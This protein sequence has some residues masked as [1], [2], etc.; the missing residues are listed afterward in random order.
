M[1]GRGITSSLVSLGTGLKPKSCAA[2][3]PVGETGV[4][5]GA[6]ADPSGGG[7][8]AR[9][10]RSEASGCTKRVTGREEEFQRL[11]NAEA[12]GIPL[13]LA[14]A[15]GRRFHHGG[16]EGRSPFAFLRKG[17]GTLLGCANHLPGKEKRQP[18]RSGQHRAD[19]ERGRDAGPTGSRETLPKAPERGSTR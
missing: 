2:T 17:R 6:R 3:L 9:K 12:P 11:G 1:G 4:L 18:P 13:G 14:P 10:G 16:A 8:T 7:S 15:F 5:A 19:A